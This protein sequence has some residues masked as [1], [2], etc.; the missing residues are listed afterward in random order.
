M[1]DNSANIL[2][3]LYLYGES[4]RKA[5]EADVK[6]SEV[7]GLNNSLQGSLDDAASLNNELE[8][9]I[10]TLVR[11]KKHLLEE[12]AKERA[13]R[14]ELVDLHD[15]LLDK[16]EALA[17]EVEELKRL[18]RKPMPE[19]AE[20]NAD[21]QATY[22]AHMEQFCGWIVSQKAFKELAI[23]LGAKNGLSAGEVIQLGHIKRIDVLENK[24]E[25]S[26]NSNAVDSPAVSNRISK[27]KQSVNK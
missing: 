19:I 26:H 21:F 15:A 14:N 8:D 11:Q 20:I 24:N 16:N 23:Q 17:K 25:A 3:G 22:E 12:F 13:Y 6:Y 2:T 7:Q 10:G 4:Q 1:S 27:L 9:E 5:Q 18:F